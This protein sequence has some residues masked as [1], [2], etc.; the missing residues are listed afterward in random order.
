[1]STTE[2][3]KALLP[4]VCALAERMPAA[5]PLERAHLLSFC[6]AAYI[7]ALRQRQAADDDEGQVSHDGV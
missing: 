5:T 2:Q 3:L 1:M 7:E 6:L 4:D